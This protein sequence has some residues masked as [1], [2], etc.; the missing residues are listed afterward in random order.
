MFARWLAL[1][2][3]REGTLEAIRSILDDLGRKLDDF[4]A[5]VRV[6]ITCA[7]LIAS[8]S[9]VAAGRLQCVLAGQL[10][11]LSPAVVT[12]LGRLGV[13]RDVNA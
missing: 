7:R 12:Q 1:V 8:S 2:S 11:E 5:I 10:V 9:A 3:E 4:D 6:E 13:L